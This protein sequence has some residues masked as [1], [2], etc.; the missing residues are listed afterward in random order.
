MASS[1]LRVFSPITDHRSLITRI[2]ASLLVALLAAAALAGDPYSLLNC[3]DFSS[4]A[5]SDYIDHRTAVAGASGI[6]FATDRDGGGISSI[7]LDG[8]EYQATPYWDENGYM[9]L[10]IRAN[11]GHFALYRYDGT[12]GL[13]T[14]QCG[15]GLSDAHFTIEGEFDSAGVY[16]FT[17]DMHSEPLN[18]RRTTLA[19]NDPSFAGA[20]TTTQAFTGVSANEDE[21]SYVRWRRDRNDVLYVFYRDGSSG[22]GNLF[23]KEWS[24]GGQ[25]WAGVGGAG[26]DGKIVD[27]SGHSPYFSCPTFTSDNKMFLAWNWRVAVTGNNITDYKWVSGVF[28]DPATDS[29]TKSDGTAQTM[30]ITDA[31][32][33]VIDN[34]DAVVITRPYVAADGQGRVHMVYQRD[35]DLVHRLWSGTGTWADSDIA[36]PIATSAQVAI[37]VRNS[38]DVAIVFTRRSS[39]QKIV[40]Y[41]SGSDDY[42]TWTGPTVIHATAVPAGEDWNGF[43]D[44]TAWQEK[45]EL[46]TTAPIAA[47]SRPFLLDQLR[48]S[49]EFSETTGNAIC[50]HTGFTFTQNGTISSVTGVGG[51]TARNY[52]TE[53]NET[54]QRNDESSQT[55]TAD[56][57]SVIWTKLDSKTADRGLWSKYNTTGNQRSMVL[58]YSQTGDKFNWTVHGAGDGTQGTAVTSTTFGAPDTTNANMVYVD[59]DAAA[60]LIGIS[61]NAGAKDTASH[62]FGIF[63]STASLNIGKGSSNTSN[64]MDGWLDKFRLWGRTLSAS[65]RTYLYNSGN[66][67]VY[68]EFNRIAPTIYSHG[69]TA[70]VNVDAGDTAVATVTAYGD[71]GMGEAL[72]GADAAS[73][74]ATDNGDG[75]WS[76]AFDS[77]AAAGT[78]SV[79]LTLDNDA[80]S[81]ATDFTVNVAGGASPWLALP[82]NQ[83]LSKWR[84]SK[85]DGFGALSL[86]P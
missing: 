3:G 55:F 75:T 8:V 34:S 85:W 2:A 74:S 58:R 68:S 32:C 6:N 78:Y 77:P 76:L 28:Y 61:I 65:E 12:G 63:D 38:D 50:E 22:D 49:L 37:V 71:L 31:N 44:Q 45:Q 40:K 48:Y 25:S 1:E 13:A 19:V 73:F 24:V 11:R 43:Y 39:D 57:S 18:Y 27:G 54:F 82:V 14:I 46:F 70:S 20:V 9:V 10:A 26:T 62:T 51:G 16:H 86:A 79:T 23:M 81:D 83:L 35:T 7:T 56:M 5:S 53:N 59:H 15:G 84:P 80:G 17:Y 60:D 66:G 29:W 72:S 69:A 67:R 33:D 42:T 30:P 21:V 41:V 64:S 47:D 4:A 36:A 52:D